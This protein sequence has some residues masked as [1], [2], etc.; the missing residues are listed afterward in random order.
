MEKQDN[1]QFKRRI[2]N[3]LLEPEIQLKRAYYFLAF[4]FCMLGGIVFWVYF[5]LV[6][7][8]EF[9][10]TEH[11]LVA[12]RI[13]DLMR[14]LSWF[15]IVAYVVTGMIS[16]IIFGIYSSHR[17]IG[18]SVA[19]RHH[20]DRLKNGNYAHNLR[21]RQGDELVTVA[22]LINELTEVLRQKYGK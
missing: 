19:I 13:T 4:F 3:Y 2:R 10:S 11:G 1:P 15:T 17:V 12:V 14:S 16:S 5:Q 18:P 8:V 9:L 21:I 22:R 20:I 7:A 6:I